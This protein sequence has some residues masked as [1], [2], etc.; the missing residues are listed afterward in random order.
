MDKFS[1]QKRSDIMSKVTSKNTKPELLV[2][3]FLHSL[4]FRYK[5]HRKDLPGNPDIVLPKHRLAVFVHGCFW[6]RHPGCSKATTPSTNQEYWNKKF[7]DN[8]ERDT[9]TIRELRE[10]N[11]IPLVIWECETRDL[12]RVWNKI[13]PCLKA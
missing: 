6:H 12:D 3:R 9:K 2:R 8:I 1:A 5:L 7:Q 10:L 13:K 11:W 4:G